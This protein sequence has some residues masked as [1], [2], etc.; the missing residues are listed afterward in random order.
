M[1]APRSAAVRVK[2]F[3]KLNLDL[4]VLYRR[5]DNY[6]ELR[7]LFHTVSLADEL[8]IEYT[9][10]SH[11]TVEIEGA[12]IPDNLVERAALSCL[13]EWDAGGQVRCHLRKRIPMGAGLGGG[14]SDAAA[15]LLTLPV[16]ARRPI[17]MKRLL[18]MAAALGSDVPFFLE[19]GAAAGLGRGEELY[20]LADRPG[21]ALIV[22]PDIHV[23][24]PD[25]YR[26]LSGQLVNPPWPQKVAAFQEFLRNPE[27]PGH[28]DFEAVVFAEHPKLELIRL[29]LCEAGA[30]WALM[31]GSGSSVFGLFRSRAQV[32]RARELFREETTFP[33]TLVSRGQFRR[34]WWRRLAPFAMEKTWPPRS[35]SEQ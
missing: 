17:A 33:V 23:S 16:L 4:R 26:A 21:C 5:A 18:E 30:Q 29:Q 35:R 25:A 6:H 10:S 3:A 14:S 8:R 2:A 22:T 24:T 27:Q 28:N 19:G 15:V 7:T 11:V 1:T 32:V 12:A 31:S 20:P 13:A 34:S 9:P